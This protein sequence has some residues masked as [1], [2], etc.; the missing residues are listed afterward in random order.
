MGTGGLNRSQRVVVAIGLGT[1]LYSLGLCL[2]AMN[3]P[4]VYGW[5]GYAPDQFT[6]NSLR[7]SQLGSFLIW[8]VLINVWVVASAFLFRSKSTKDTD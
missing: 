2:T 1:L 6:N 4:S 7:M 5:V 8:F 3:S